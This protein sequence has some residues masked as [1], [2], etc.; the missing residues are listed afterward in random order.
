MVSSELKDGVFKVSISQY[1]KDPGY[2]QVK[3]IADDFSSG[4]KGSLKLP[5]ATRSW[6]SFC[7][8]AKRKRMGAI[9]NQHRQLRAERL[10]F[11]SLLQCKI[12]QL[13][14]QHTFVLHLQ[15][16]FVPDLERDV[17]IQK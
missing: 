15:T 3:L 13:D 7:C 2:Y 11:Q 4:G 9:D 16:Y 1:Q 17:I 12:Y 6:L 5:F 10:S 8:F 14:F